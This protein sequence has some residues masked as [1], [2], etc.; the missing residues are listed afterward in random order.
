MSICLE[1]FVEQ[2][3]CFLNEAERAEVI[4]A[5]SNF[6]DQLVAKFELP[7]SQFL[8]AYVQQLV[9]HIR[10]D[11]IEF[12]RRHVLPQGKL[13]FERGGFIAIDADEFQR[14]TVDVEFRVIRR[15]G[16]ENAAGEFGARGFRF[17]I[18]R[19]MFSWPKF[20][21]RHINNDALRL[22]FCNLTTGQQL[23]GAK[24]ETKFLW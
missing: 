13:Q 20:P 12:Q 8:A 14:G 11:L 15:S 3:I 2:Q 18:E 4:P 21:N 5:L 17:E 9:M 1:A 19:V 22:N 24:I 10:P 23:I 6:V 16:S 7:R